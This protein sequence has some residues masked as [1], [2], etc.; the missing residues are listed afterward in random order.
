[1]PLA[2]I[3]ACALSPQQVLPLALL[4]DALKSQA[5]LLAARG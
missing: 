4:V 2:A 1:M 3:K 5:A